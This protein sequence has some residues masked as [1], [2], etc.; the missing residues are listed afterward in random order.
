[1]SS[2]CSAA[3]IQTRGEGKLINM[4]KHSS[5]LSYYPVTG[6]YCSLIRSSVFLIR[7]SVF[8]TGFF[9]LSFALQAALSLA[10]VVESVC[11][12]TG[13]PDNSQEAFKNIFFIYS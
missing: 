10:E 9:A 7:S 13:K 11:S 4:L 12:L 8:L 2:V 3:K 5:E 1:M 6:I